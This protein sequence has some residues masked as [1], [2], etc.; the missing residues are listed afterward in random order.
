M[1]RIFQMGILVSM[2]IFGAVLMSTRRKLRP[3]TPLPEGSV[4]RRCW[5]AIGFGQLPMPVYCRIGG[6]EPTISVGAPAI[7]AIIK[8]TKAVS[9]GR[10]VENGMPAAVNAALRISISS[11]GGSGRFKPNTKLLVFC[12]PEATFQLDATNK[13][14]ICI[15]RK[16]DSGSPS[17][18]RRLTLPD[19]LFKNSRN[20]IC[21]CEEITRQATTSFIFSVSSRATS[22][23]FC[24]RAARTTASPA[25]LPAF[26]PSALASETFPSTKSLYFQICFSLG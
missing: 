19:F 24:N 5:R 17:V 12:A 25:S 20:N 16:R 6:L 22:A 18:Y 9:G 10:C 1:K 3:L 11:L 13:F 21:S 2:T 23:S 26:I 14:P 7:V 4:S 15:A 8:P